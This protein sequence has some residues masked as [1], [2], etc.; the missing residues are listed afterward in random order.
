[1]S[2]LNA[3]INRVGDVLLREE[4]QDRVDIVQHKIR[5]MEKVPVM[6]LDSGNNA[7]NELEW[8]LDAAGGELVAGPGL[9]RVLIFQETGTGMLQLMGTVPGLLDTGWPAVEYDRVY[10]WEAP[11][12]AA[13]DAPRAVEALEDIA[14]MLYPGHF[15]FGNEGRNWM[16]FKMQ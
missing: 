5:F 13:V 7:V 1:M 12:S 4:L 16:S 11:D 2:L 6:F 3:V 10:L 15:V 14:E 8:L 9:A